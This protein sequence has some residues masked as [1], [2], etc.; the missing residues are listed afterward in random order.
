MKINLSFIK[1]TVVTAAYVHFVYMPALY[2]DRG[3]VFVRRISGY[4][5]TYQCSSYHKNYR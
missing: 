1:Y 5:F 4:R 3:F 2:S